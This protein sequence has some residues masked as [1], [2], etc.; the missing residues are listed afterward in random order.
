MC[1]PMTPPAFLP[2]ADSPHKGPPS[3]SGCSST[4][5]QLTMHVCV[6]VCVCVCVHMRVHLCT[7]YI[8]NSS[9]HIP[10]RSACLKL[11]LKPSL[12]GIVM[13]VKRWPAK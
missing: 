5:R 9:S 6:C 4:N 3:Q 10:R 12:K 13:S 11:Q 7:L 1:L 8:C 2:P